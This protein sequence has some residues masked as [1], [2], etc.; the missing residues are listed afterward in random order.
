MCGVWAGGLELRIEYGWNGLAPISMNYFSYIVC[1]GRARMRLRCLFT[2]FSDMKKG[3]RNRGDKDT[4]SPLFSV[5]V[6]K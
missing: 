6:D 3:Q 4:L 1:A 2:D 5:G